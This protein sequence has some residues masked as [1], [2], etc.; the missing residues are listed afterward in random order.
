MVK[1]II[2]KSL[3]VSY[4]KKQAI[5]NLSLS[6][7]KNEILGIIGPT[8]SG[9]TT[10]LTVL[11]RMID[12]IPSAVISGSVSMGDIDVLTTPNIHSLRRSVGMIFALPVALPMT[13]RE[14]VEYG[15]KMAGEAKGEL[16]TR[17][18]ESLVQAGLWDEVHDR[19]DTPAL[20]L[21]GGQQQRLCIARALALKPKVLLLDEPCSGLDPISTSRIEDTL[22]QLK[23]DMTIILVT[24]I[25]HQAARVAH[26]TAFMLEGELVELADTDT[27]FTNPADNR[28]KEYIEGKFG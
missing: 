20:K 15:P 8:T 7:E 4:G 21:S 18:E 25:P 24:N 10:L 26:R 19:L 3:S 9:K 16:K 28:T 14:N 5:R 6:V 17:V 11:N 1:E 22:G 12:T 13:I 2:I 23:N 27:L